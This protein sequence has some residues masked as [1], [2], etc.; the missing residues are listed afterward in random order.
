M[1]QHLPVGD[2]KWI[3]DIKDFNLMSVPDDDSK[4]YIL[5]V[6]LG[7]LYLLFCVCVCVCVSVYYYYFKHFYSY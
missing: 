2:F 4:G 3:D 5:E 6:D 1:S 7:M